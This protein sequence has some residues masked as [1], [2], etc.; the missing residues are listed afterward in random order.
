MVRLVTLVVVVLAAAALL[1]G[2]WALVKGVF[3]RRRPQERR[4]G[5]YQWER[6]TDQVYRQ[7]KG[8]RGPSADADGM[9]RFLDGHRGVEAYVEPRTAIHPLSVVLV[10]EDGEWRRFELADDSLLRSL[11]RAR[12]LPMFDAARVGY[13]PRMRRRSRP[14]PED[15][16]P[17]PGPP[18]GP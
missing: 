5:R 3:T 16:G 8:V 1:W 2:V 12:G 6:R 13:P 7:V 9:V 14:R 18:D 10:D 4:A 11:A 17:P 15:D